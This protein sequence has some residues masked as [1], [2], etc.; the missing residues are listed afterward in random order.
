V[1][2]IRLR[3]ASKSAPSRRIISKPPPLAAVVY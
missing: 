3:D 2:V 1:K